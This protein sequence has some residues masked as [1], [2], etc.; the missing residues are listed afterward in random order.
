MKIRKVIGGLLVSA[1]FVAIGIFAVRVGGPKALLFS[2]GTS[3]IIVGLI[4][5]GFY[6]LYK[7]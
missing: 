7:E 3:V 6:L 1:P 2:F 5:L 4:C